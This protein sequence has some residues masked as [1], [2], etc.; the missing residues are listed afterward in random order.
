MGKK[1]VILLIV[2]LF[3]FLFFLVYFNGQKSANSNQENPIP[4]SNQENPTA[5]A[6]QTTCGYTQ[7]DINNG[8]ISTSV[9]NTCD[10]VTTYTATDLKTIGCTPSTCGFNCNCSGTPGTVV[11]SNSQNLVIDTVSGV[12]GFVSPLTPN[13]AV[14]YS[15]PTGGANQ[16]YILCNT[17]GIGSSGQN[18]IAICAGKFKNASGEYINIMYFLFNKQP[19]NY[20]AVLRWKLNISGYNTSKIQCTAKKCEANGPGFYLCLVSL[21]N[22]GK[23]NEIA[24]TSNNCKVGNQCNGNNNEGGFP[25]SYSGTGTGIAV[26]KD[27]VRIAFAITP[28]PSNNNTS[29]LSGLSTSTLILQT[30]SWIS[31]Y[32]NS[33]KTIL[34]TTPFE[35]GEIFFETAE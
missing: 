18:N 26:G 25:L 22:P 29:Y 32:P 3:L 20:G 33:P 5:M 4:A 17:Q 14:G 24:F 13:Y 9:A 16:D 15:N 6:T 35:I 28:N 12:L 2:L 19:Q 34:D 1:L 27:P 23:S 10:C 11:I 21:V 30:N 7:N 8:Y 31:A